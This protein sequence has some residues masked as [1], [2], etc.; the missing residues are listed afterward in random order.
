MEDV[1]AGPAGPAGDVLPSPFPAIAGPTSGP[2]PGPIGGPIPGPIA[3]PS[4]PPPAPQPA[5]ERFYCPFPGCNR[6]FAELWRL[7]VHYRAPPDIRGSGKERGHGKELDLCPKC[8]KTLKPGKHH[9]GCTGST[10][11]S[12]LK[13]SRQA[14]VILPGYSFGVEGRRVSWV[15]LLCGPT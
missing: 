12:H 15:P 4:V 14:Q 1:A 11:A 5:G 2:I 8:G 10:K 9:V 6:S 7:K 13:R 3:G